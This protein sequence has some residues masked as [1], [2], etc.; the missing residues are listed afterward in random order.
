MKYRNI[1]LTKFIFAFCVI[2]L[3]S[4]QQCQRCIVISQGKSAESSSSGE[5]IPSSTPEITSE[6]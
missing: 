4:S 6:A 1:D 3:A 2:V 5:M